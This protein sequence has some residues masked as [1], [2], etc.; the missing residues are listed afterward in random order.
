MTPSLANTRRW[1]RHLVDLPVQVVLPS[2]ASR[3]LVP[4]RLAEISAGG[5]VLYAGVPLEPGDRMEVE[6]QTPPAQVTGIIR[7]RTGY[8][9][10]VEFLT[11]L[12]IDNGALNR[13]LARFQQK[14]RAYLQQK[15]QEM[16]R[17][18]REI[19]ELC[20]AAQLAPGKKKR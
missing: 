11:P 2:G 8:C 19:A 17:L 4:G 3:V 9:F 6:F 14:H 18:H 5:M 12:A 1:P 13:S 10:A 15:E 16:D 20:H 7:E